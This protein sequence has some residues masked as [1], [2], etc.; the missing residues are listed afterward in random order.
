MTPDYMKRQLSLTFIER[1]TMKN[2]ILVI[3]DE[4]KLR[5]LLS[6]IISLEGFE[7]IEAANVKAALKKL[8][9]Q[10]VDVIICDV[11]LPDGNGVELWKL[12]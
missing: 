2:N 10:D 11:K 5:N 8:E 6:R 7:V 12:R 3:D 1:L 9:Q 4:E